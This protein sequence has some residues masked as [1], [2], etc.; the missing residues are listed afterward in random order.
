M[1]TKRMG[2]PR[3]WVLPSLLPL[4]EDGYLLFPRIHLQPFS[5]SLTEK[6]KATS[7]ERPDL[8]FSPLNGK[9]CKKTASSTASTG[10]LDCVKA[11]WY[12]FNSIPPIGDQNRPCINVF[13]NAGWS[14]QNI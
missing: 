8:H 11:L 6:Q 14:L 4:V 9:A 12:L 13:M 3:K 7:L 2:V 10:V 5:L 1:C